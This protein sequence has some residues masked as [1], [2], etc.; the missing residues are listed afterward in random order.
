MPWI[1]G[2]ILIAA[3]MTPANGIPLAASAAM[4]ASL[5]VEALIR[6]PRPGNSRN[7][8]RRTGEAADSVVGRCPSW[9]PEIG[10]GGWRR[11]RRNPPAIDDLSWQAGRA[12]GRRCRGR[13]YGSHPGRIRPADRVVIDG[14]GSCRQHRE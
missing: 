9:G 1:S 6:L 3:P 13:A 11:P 4:E 2:V 8:H 5:L 12:P 14:G 10:R 7:A